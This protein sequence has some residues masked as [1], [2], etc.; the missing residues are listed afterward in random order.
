MSSPPKTLRA[1]GRYALPLALAAAS[2]AL[3]STPKKAEF[4]PR[5]R[6]Y[7]ADPNTVSFVR[8]GLNIQIV[9]A[10]IASDGTISVDYKLTDQKTAPLDRL[11]V[12]T[13]GAVTLGFV[14]AYIPKGQSQFVSYATRSRTSTDGKVTVTQA[15]AD[16]GGAT[17]QVAD[18]EYVYTFKTLAPAGWDPT[19]TQRVGI[20]GNR[21]LTEFD[22]GTYYDDATFDWVPAGGKPAPRDVVRTAACNKCHDQLAHHGG[23]RRSVEM[24][25]L[26][27]T[28]Q[29]SEPNSGNTVDF[30][31]MIHKIHMGSQ[32]PSVKA[33][34]PYQIGGGANPDDWS[35]VVF[36]SDPRRCEACHDA[37]SGAAQASAWLTKPNRAACG[38]CH[39]DIN[40]AT[41]Q[42]HISGVNLPQVSDNQCADCHIPQ[43]ELEFDASIRGG[44]TIPQYSDTRPGIVAHILKVDNGA[45][46]KKPTVTFTLR[47]SQ[48]NGI[49]LSTLTASPNRVSL[50]MTGPTTDYGN[51]S[52]G[53]DVTTPGY[54]TENPV[55][56]GQCS[57]D[58]TCAYTFTHAIPAGAKGTF[59]IGIEARRALVLGAGTLQQQSTQYGADNKVFYFPVD[60]SPVAKRRQVVDISKCNGCHTRLSMHGEN[61][62]Q[63]EYCV[64]CHNPGNTASGTPRQAINFSLMI[65]KIHFGENLAQY[66]ATYSIGSSDFTDVRYPVMSDTG[67]AGDTAKCDMC[68]V[69]NSE[70]VFPIG[71]NA[72]TTPQGLM[73]P[74]TPATTA[75]CTA[76]HVTTS[77]TAHASTQTDGKYGESC[78][79]CHG[80]NA[81][82]SVLKEHAGK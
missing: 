80:A 25:V 9:S 1:A 5:D 56:T 71:L 66:G 79:V 73:N 52:F 29:T 77:A 63:T 59:A 21:N 11:G 82:F 35:T 7:Y 17:Q 41:G 45:A 53:P 60:G 13:P 50:N 74:T 23:S 72:V 70:A 8:P 64:F 20:Y 58:G 6:A 48:G 30:K 37:N 40:F 81:D 15:A 54:V 36:P 14:V 33:G 2:V 24:C 68:H 49:P 10:K 28:G 75:A 55:A 27:H 4:T 62:N 18:G 46:G 16:S 32:L 43:G 3:S 19:A 65:H 12:V 47:D 67:A 69:N 61:R 39:D 34:K 78:D 76:C 51:T 26:C 42:N 44:H 22:L 38:S 57:P 31:V